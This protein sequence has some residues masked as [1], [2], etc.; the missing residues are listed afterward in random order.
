[1]GCNHMRTWRLSFRKT[2]R[3]GRKR[4]QSSR[5]YPD[6]RRS[7]IRDS[8]YLLSSSL[9]SLSLFNKLNNSSC[10]WSKRSRL[11]RN[12]S[13]FQCR[14]SL[15]L[16]INSLERSTCRYSI[17]MTLTSSKSWR[18]ANEIKEDSWCLNQPLT[19]TLLFQSLANRLWEQDIFQI[20]GLSSPCQSVRK[21]IR[22]KANLPQ[23]LMNSRNKSRIL[24]NRFC[25]SKNSNN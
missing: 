19:I 25:H 1:M 10:S 8:C 13:Q 23:F 21:W 12:K 14:V 18:A 2:I 20:Q 15:C 5:S 7:T 17:R 9:Y 6:M 16:R 24:R 11:Q 4:I 22:P 3:K